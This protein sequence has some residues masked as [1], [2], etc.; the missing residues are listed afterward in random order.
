MT[1]KPPVEKLPNMLPAFK[2]LDCKKREYAHLASNPA[3]K[4]FSLNAK[5][6]LGN[7]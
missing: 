6:M 7:T 4:F 5:S 3:R 1:K 2:P